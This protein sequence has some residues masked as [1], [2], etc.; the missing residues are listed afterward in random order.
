MRTFAPPSQTIASEAALVRSVWASLPDQPLS[1]AGLY[2]KLRN[3]G[4]LAGSADL[5]GFVSRLVS[6]G[7]LV[8]DGEAFR[9]GSLPRR[10]VREDSGEIRASRQADS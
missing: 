7:V 1:E 10:G 8:R 9:R 3:V 2:A 5:D 6:R 4:R